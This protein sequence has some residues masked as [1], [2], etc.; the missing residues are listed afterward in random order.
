VQYEGVIVD[1][2]VITG[3]QALAN[4]QNNFETFAISPNPTN[5]I[6]TVKLTTSEDV[7]V[8]LYDISGR[9]CFTNEYKNVSTTF[10]QEINLGQLEK[11]VYLLTVTSE[12][13]TQT[14]KVMVE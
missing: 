5:G 1:N 7:K 14:K 8:D 13:K 9:K 10:N 3:T 4:Q 6:V 12:G 11:G 2:F